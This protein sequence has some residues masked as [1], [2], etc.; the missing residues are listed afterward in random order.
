M[1][2]DVCRPNKIT[3]CNGINSFII[4]LIIDIL[5]L[6]KFVSYMWLTKPIEAFWSE[7]DCKVATVACNMHK[8][9]GNHSSWHDRYFLLR[10]CNQRID[11]HWLILD[12]NHFAKSQWGIKNR[13]RPTTTYE[14]LK[15]LFLFFPKNLSFVTVI[16]QSD[17][18]MFL[19][20]LP[21][22]RQSNTFTAN[23]CV[24]LNII[25]LIVVRF[26]S[27]LET[28]VSFYFWNLLHKSHPEELKSS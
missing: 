7:I 15:R 13:N 2:C 9:D 17:A 18:V 25:N 28:F 14:D 16:P 4:P 27:K 19:Q 26:L 24:C 23:L 1:L 5:S 22:G 11:V 21:L 8:I 3:V 10:N 6:S 20:Y 12:S